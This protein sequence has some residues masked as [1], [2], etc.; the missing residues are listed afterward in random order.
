MAVTNMLFT[1]TPDGKHI[2]H[3]ATSAFLV[4]NND[5]YAYATYMGAKSA[6][7]AMHM[8]AAH[9]RWGA[10]TTCTYETAYNIA[11]D[12]DLPFFDRLA[13]YMRSVRSSEGVDFKHLIVGF[14]WQ[15]IY[16]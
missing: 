16:T 15:D 13:R 9:G 1:E 8:A 5:A 10:E 6:P 2:S 14:K 4:Q 11:F 3:S 12:T 7:M